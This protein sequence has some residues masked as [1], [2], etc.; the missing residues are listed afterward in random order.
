MKSKIILEQGKHHNNEVVFVIFPK[1]P[2]LISVIKTLGVAHWS[3]TQGKWYI[4]KSE[5]DLS[6]VFSAL[7][8]KSYLDYS[9]LKGITST[10]KNN[11]KK[12]TLKI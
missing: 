8:E 6:K 11:E 3:Q 12:E 2:E 10:Q 4:L 1:D 9:G 5:F 7:Q